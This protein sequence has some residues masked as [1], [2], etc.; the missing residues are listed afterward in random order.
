MLP[1]RSQGQPRGHVTLPFVALV[2]CL[3]GFLNCHQYTD[4]SEQPALV[5]SDHEANIK[6]PSIVHFVQLKKYENSKLHFS[7]ESFLALYSA[8][9]FIQPSLIYI[10]TDFNDEI[11]DAKRHGSSWT[12]KLLTAFPDVVKLNQVF[13]PVEANGQRIILVEHRSDFERLDQLAL[14]GGIYLDWDV[15]TLRSPVPLCL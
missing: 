1:I 11:A 9:S 3:I 2:A 13:A 15:L 5:P 7:F 10:H 8:Y 12:K 6:I 14:L 4:L